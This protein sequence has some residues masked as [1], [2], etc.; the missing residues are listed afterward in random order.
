MSNDS[1]WHGLAVAEFII[2]MAL[3]FAAVRFVPDPVHNADA[4]VLLF[5]HSSVKRGFQR[6][7]RPNASISSAIFLRWSVLSPE[8][9]ACST[10]VAT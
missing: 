10:Q 7:A 8:E 5:P 9:I 4:I 1:M 2:Q 6:L 3:P